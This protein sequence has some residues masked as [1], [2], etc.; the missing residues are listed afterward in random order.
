MRS[1]ILIAGIIIARAIDTT[2][3]SDAF[4]QLIVLLVVC[5]AIVDVVELLK[6]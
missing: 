5:F 2:T 6:E 3:P 1:A 4:M